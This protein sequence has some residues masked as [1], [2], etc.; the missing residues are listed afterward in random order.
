M[1]IQVQT[2]SLLSAMQA[3]A[4]G[5]MLWIGVQGGEHRAVASLRLRAAALAVEGA[6]YATLAFQNYFTP[7]VLTLGGNAFALL[8]Q[9]MSVIALRMLLGAPMRWR[10]VIA[11]GVIGWLGVAWFAVVQP[12]YH[13]RVLW[14]SLAIACNL[15]LNI[16]V[17]AGGCH[18]G[19]S[20]ARCV[21]LWIF[22]LSLLLLVWRNGALWL[23]SNQPGSAWV[24]SS[25]NV[26]FVLLSGMQPLFDSL[27]FLLLYNELLQREL[28]SLARLDPLTGVANRLALEEAA[29]RM[30]AATGA[31]N[32]ALSLLLVDADHFK[33]VNDRFGHD[34][35]DKVLK[36]LVTNIRSV[37]RGGDVV[38]RLGGEEFIVL[39]QG[40][41]IRSS[42]A[43]AERIRAAVEHSPMAVG[44]H[45]LQLTIS[46][47]VAVAIPGDREIASILRRA[48]KAL[49][50]AKRG[51]RNRV[52]GMQMGQE[53]EPQLV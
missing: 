15:L 38:G 12:D 42:V 25:T 2:L 1:P 22:I 9:A 24:P 40:A 30:L 48:D 16:Q 31:P 21:L 43:L 51:G 4:L 46:I 19:G 7:A 45:V 36:E 26:F 34:C 5:L 6:G 50:A 28:H 32:G 53:G 47:G 39:T 20:H 8:A 52:M 3:V 27:G 29:R 13:N 37:L 35:G 17:L 23:G 44:E 14:G 18:R 49:Y 33:S 10:A 11:V 41:D